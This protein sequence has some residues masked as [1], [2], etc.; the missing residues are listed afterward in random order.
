M[1]ALL[2]SSECVVILARSSTRSGERSSHRSAAPDVGQ[3]I[4]AAFWQRQG[5]DQAE[6]RTSWRLV[7]SEI[8]TSG[9]NAPL[10]F[11]AR[12]EALDRTAVVGQMVWMPQLL[13]ANAFCAGLD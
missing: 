8:L 10:M 2:P 7:A 13:M 1:N 9:A 5:R 4:V 6:S 12:K 11:R 3:S